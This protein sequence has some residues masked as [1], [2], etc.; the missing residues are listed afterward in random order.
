MTKFGKRYDDLH[1]S[2]DSTITWTLILILL[3]FLYRLPALVFLDILFQSVIDCST[4][5]AI[6]REPFAH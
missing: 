1:P 6:Q 4:V 2:S 3:S 5:E